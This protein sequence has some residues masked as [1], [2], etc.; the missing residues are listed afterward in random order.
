MPIW[1]KDK[2]NMRRT[3]Q[4][5]IK[6]IFNTSCNNIHFCYHHLSHASLGFHTSPFEKCAILVVDAVGEDS[7]T[8]IF[9]ASN[10][11]F[12]LLASQQFPHSLGLLYSSFTYYLGFKVNS[13][14]Y[15]VM[16]LA[17]YGNTSSQEYKAYI[18]LILHNLVYIQDDGSIK[19]NEKYFSFMYSDRMIDDSKWYKLFGIPI[20]KAEDPIL[21]SHMSLAKA[22]QDVTETILM[23][24]VDFA[25]NLTGENNLCVVGGCALNCAA[26]GKLKQISTLNSIY[27]PY[28][29]GDDG[30]A[31]GCAIYGCNY[32]EKVKTESSPYLGPDF[33]EVEIQ[34]AIDKI[35]LKS[36]S[37]PEED[38]LYDM[39]SKEL[40]EGKIIGWFQG[41]MEFGPRALGNRSIL[42]DP[43]NPEM[44]EIINS[45]IKYR[46]AFRPFA[47]VVL[48]EYADKMF[49]KVEDSP[50]M[51]ATFYLRP[52]ESNYPAITHIDKTARIQTVTE[53]QNIKLYKL[54]CSFNKLTGC[55]LL[56][57]T[58]FNVMGEPI[59]CTP[60][61][62]LNTFKKT[63]MDVLVINN[64]I[65]RKS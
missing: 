7:T 40:S 60:T 45:K 58:S 46:E 57:N 55:P 48:K 52:N 49:D 47:P 27:V 61:D 4:K 50:Y 36:E 64:F 62:A 6:R 22:I 9:R 56:L 37:I 32:A 14:E 24:M 13:D 63:G 5:E 3:I 53:N 10:S 51:S 19:L 59:V 20:R 8:S 43:R 29:P 2:I 16:G 44:K 35:G 28:A 34:T 23:K 54:L 30:A 33:T 21:E 18:D 11:G 12:E 39:I 15:K 1:L 41:R 17:P 65:I 42:A 31:I 26:I 38:I 25:R